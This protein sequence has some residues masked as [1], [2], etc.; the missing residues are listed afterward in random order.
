M[1]ITVPQVCGHSNDEER[2]QKLEAYQEEIMQKKMN[3]EVV[4]PHTVGLFNVMYALLYQYQQDS[5]NRILDGKPKQFTVYEGKKTYTFVECDALAY[6]LDYAG[7]REPVYNAAILDE[8][9]KA[10]VDIC[11]SQKELL[12]KTNEI[13]KIIKEKE[14][15]DKIE[16]S[17]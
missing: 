6:L 1:N 8:Y 3:G 15:R 16:N 12:N 17:I 10:F 7:K 2:N 9:H 14:K 5:I 13:I 11:E 4:D